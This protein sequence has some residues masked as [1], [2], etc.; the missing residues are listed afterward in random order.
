MAGICLGNV[1]WKN[2]NPSLAQLLASM[3]DSSGYRLRF[4]TI[5]PVQKTGC[6]FVGISVA[7]ILMTEWNED[8]ISATLDRVGKIR[9]LFRNCYVIFAVSS[10]EA[11]QCFI[12]AYFRSKSI[13]IAMP[14]FI[15]V[16]DG[17]MA[18]ERMLNVAY[19]HA[20]MVNFSFVATQCFLLR[21]EL[22]CSSEAFVAAI[23][24]IRGLSPHDANTLQQGIGSI[25]EIMGASKEEIMENTDLSAEKAEAMAKFFHDAEYYMTPI[26]LNH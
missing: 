25:E 17:P 18:L 14:P 20:G 16:T 19:V 8:T 6:P 22:V 3:L 11:N 13:E 4:L 2:S 23:S 24:S 10:N 26:P 5:A 9:K 7:F 12:N 1:H 15:P 21:E